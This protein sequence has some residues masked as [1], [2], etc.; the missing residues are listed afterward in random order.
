MMS[1]PSGNLFHDIRMDH[2]MLYQLLEL[3]DLSE[4]RWCLSDTIIVKT[5]LSSGLISELRRDMKPSCLKRSS[6]SLE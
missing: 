6:W 2:I 3:V 1:H 5:S 4:L